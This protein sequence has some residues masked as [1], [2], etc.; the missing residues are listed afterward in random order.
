M[1]VI[2]IR[3]FLGCERYTGI[4]ISHFSNAKKMSSCP[5]AGDD[6]LLIDFGGNK[7]IKYLKWGNIIMLNGKCFYNK[8]SIDAALPGP[9]V[10]ERMI[11][12]NNDKK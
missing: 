8:Q 12:K 9:D 6:Y 4:I 3:C 10:F 5:K 2:K 11:D 1:Y 7:T